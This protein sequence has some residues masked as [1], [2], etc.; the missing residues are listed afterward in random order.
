MVF[1]QQVEI[2][3]EL[4][5]VEVDLEVISAIGLQPILGWGHRLDVEYVQ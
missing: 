2:D 4:F 5:V 1:F 3:M